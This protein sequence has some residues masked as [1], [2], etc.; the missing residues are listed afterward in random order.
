[1]RRREFVRK[2]FE[3]TEVGILVPK[4]SY[5]FIRNNLV[6]PILSKT[7]SS[8]ATL[9]RCEY[10]CSS[11]AW[12]GLSRQHYPDALLE[13]YNLDLE[14]PNSLLLIKDIEVPKGY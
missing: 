5:F 7:G 8:F 3:I 1:M 14:K 10:S 12:L 11:R 4:I 9:S 13:I 2:V 6:Q